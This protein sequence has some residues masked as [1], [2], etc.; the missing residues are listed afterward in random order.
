M[1]EVCSADP[2]SSQLLHQKWLNPIA[3]LLACQ[4]TMPAVLLLVIRMNRIAR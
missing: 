2:R 4:Q 1:L 3:K